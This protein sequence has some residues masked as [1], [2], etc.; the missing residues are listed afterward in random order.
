MTVTHNRVRYWADQRGWTK[1]ELFGYAKL[2]K[3]SIG[4]STIDRFYTDPGYLGNH[5]SLEAI[6]RVFGL[7]YSDMIVDV[8]VPVPEQLN[9]SK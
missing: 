9:N 2:G 4:K 6:A 1:E 8:D 3:E 7:R 5:A